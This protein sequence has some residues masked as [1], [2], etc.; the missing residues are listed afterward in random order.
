MH[1]A[2]YA[3]TQA[4]PSH[5]WRTRN[6]ER[7]LAISWTRNRSSNAMREARG[8]HCSVPKLDKRR[9]RACR[10]WYG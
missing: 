10:E 6:I 8:W 4:A 1:F 7:L 2:I 9:A 5:R 3:L